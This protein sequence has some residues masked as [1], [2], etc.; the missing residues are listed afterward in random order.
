M[1]NLTLSACLAVAATASATEMKDPEE[2]A[3]EWNQTIE[4][5]R[6]PVLPAE[7]LGL[8]ATT[9]RS[10]PLPSGPIQRIQGSGGIE[11]LYDAPRGTAPES[12]IRRNGDVLEI[13]QDLP[14]DP[15]F[16][17][18]VPGSDKPPPD[19]KPWYYRGQKSWLIPIASAEPGGQMAPASSR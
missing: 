7:P 16:V 9:Q 8:T 6:E 13:P 3:G 11:P 19:A 18:I 4:A 14:I 10:I 15:R 1:K 12:R 5:A 2:V 17:R